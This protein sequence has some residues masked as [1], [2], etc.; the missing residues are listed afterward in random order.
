LARLNA[1]LNWAVDKDRILVSPS[2]GVKPPTREKTRDRWLNDQ[3]IVWFWRACDQLGY[4]FD[5][6]FKTL[7]LT[8]QRSAETASMEW[9]ELDFEAKLW[10]IPRSKA[11]SDRTHEVQLAEPVIEL[12]RAQPR[13]WPHVFTGKTG[14]PVTGFPHGKA[15]LD[16]AME[17]IA[18]DAKVEKFNTHD[19]RRTA[20]SH[21]A[22]LGF[23]AEVCDR[24]LNHSSGA[25]SGVAAVYN[26]YEFADE[27]RA[28]L[29]A[30]SSYVTGLLS[31]VPSN[32]LPLREHKK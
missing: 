20:V 28:A 17:A 6:L 8:A 1:A 21:M 32:V 9:S 29:A 4:P 12:L 22:R 13:R 3:E 15:R 31:P 16:A 27:R 23:A 25:I 11:K 24:I 26:R 30:W 7:L 5:G 10:V 14:R 19:L 2:R 18:G